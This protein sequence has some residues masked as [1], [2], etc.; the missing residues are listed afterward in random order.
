[1]TRAAGDVFLVPFAS[2]I[3]AGGRSHQV[4]AFMDEEKRQNK[5]KNI[6]Q[7]GPRESN[8]SPLHQPLILAHFLCEITHCFSKLTSRHGTATFYRVHGFGKPF[9]F[10]RPHPSR[11]PLSI[12]KTRHRIISVPP[13]DLFPLLL[14]NA[15]SNHSYILDPATRSYQIRFMTSKFTINQLEIHDSIK[16]APARI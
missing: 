5:K 2:I 14:M 12:S 13:A 3:Q 4:A 11:F 16:G 9:E 7:I 15:S 6:T 8:S 1:M 10:Q